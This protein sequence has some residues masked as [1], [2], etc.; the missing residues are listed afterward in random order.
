M[1]FLETALEFYCGS[2]REIDYTQYSEMFQIA[3]KMLPCS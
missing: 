1:N 3:Y 2:L